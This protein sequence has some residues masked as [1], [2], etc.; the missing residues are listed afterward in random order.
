MEVVSGSFQ[1][2]WY[3]QFSHF[4]QYHPI[5][6]IVLI[7]S[8]V[9]IPLVLTAFI[10]AIIYQKQ[11]EAHANAQQA[12]KITAYNDWGNNP[13]NDPWYVQGM[14][15][16]YPE[17]RERYWQYVVFAYC[18]NCGLS[19]SVTLDKKYAQRVADKSCSQ[20][21]YKTLIPHKQTKEQWDHNQLQFK[22][23]AT[24]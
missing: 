15:N 21:G 3:G 19:Q 14:E 18:K 24:A 2:D 9:I 1:G 7:C 6:T 5:L 17:Q 23:R 11:C 10:K 4:I 16:W 20:C 8:A 12:S 22:K 13:T